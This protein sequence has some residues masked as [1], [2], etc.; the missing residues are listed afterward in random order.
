MR[1]FSTSFG[2]VNG[3]GIYLY[4]AAIR[5]SEEDAQTNARFDA[6]IFRSYVES[7]V[8]GKPPNQI[9]FPDY[10]KVWMEHRDP[11]PKRKKPIRT[12]LDHHD[13]NLGKR[14]AVLNCAQ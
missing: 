11:N 14:V 13:S 2:P 5:S 8:R 7:F 1:L 12:S 10:K 3:S 4:N 9:S 6:P